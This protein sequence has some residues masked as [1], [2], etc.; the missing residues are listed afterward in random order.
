M[1]SR[2]IWTKKNRK[3][4][5]TL[6]PNYNWSVIKNYLHLHVAVSTKLRTKEITRLVNRIGYSG[7]ITGRFKKRFYQ[8]EFELWGFSDLQDVIYA[9]SNIGRMNVEGLSFAHK[10]QIYDAWL[11]EFI[12]SKI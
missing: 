7:N 4:V 5:I 2:L 8:I 3:G 12:S 11:K 6:L 10:N 9:L 1:L